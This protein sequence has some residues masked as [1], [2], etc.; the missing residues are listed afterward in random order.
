V[1][2][3]ALPSIVQPGATPEVMRTALAD[4]M[5]RRFFR[6]T[7]CSICVK[8]AHDHALHPRCDQIVYWSFNA[9]SKNTKGAFQLI[10][11]SFKE[12]AP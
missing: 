3:A 10:A 6:T 8:G 5:R 2:T 9:A 11:I 7:A 12:Y 1:A 4:L